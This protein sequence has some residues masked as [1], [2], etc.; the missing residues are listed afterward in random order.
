V[1]PVEPPDEPEGF[2]ERTRRR[3]RAW[4][5]K[6]DPLHRGRPPDYWRW[7]AEPL[8]E[9]FRERCGWAA[10]YI[11]DGNVEHFVSWDECKHEHPELAYEWSNYRYILPRLNS[12]K[13]G[14]RHLLDPFEVGPGWFRVELPSCL[15]VCTD[16]IPPE[17]RARAQRT[18]ECLG[19]VG[20][21]DRKLRRL[22]E[23]WL[24]RYRCD[25]LSLAGLMEFAPLVGRAV[26]ELHQAD[27]AQLEPE[28]RAYRAQLFAERSSVP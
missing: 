24:H 21:E 5:E 8:R 10:M 15:M 7:C 3:G 14:A 6:N 12:R 9:A 17:H 19:P 20:D 18:L 1:I 22:R 13:Q 4:L 25:Q 11:A 26:V 27:P 16:E 23:R 28:L 2:E